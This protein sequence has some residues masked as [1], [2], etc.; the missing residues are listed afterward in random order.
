S[1]EDV[2]VRPN[3]GRQVD[4]SE[5]SRGLPLA[6]QDGVTA[7][8]AK[9]PCCV[10]TTCS[11]RTCKRLG[12]IASAQVLIANWCWADFV[13]VDDGGQMTCVGCGTCCSSIENVRLHPLFTKDASVAVAG[14]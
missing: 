9:I 8:R 1:P 3:R 7:H 14:L 12:C 2:R 10:A 5:V 4:V 6:R 11:D 13:V